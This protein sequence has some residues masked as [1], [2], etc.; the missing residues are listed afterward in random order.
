MKQFKAWRYKCD[1]CG[2]NGRQKSS[3]VRH[4]IGCTANPDRICKIHHH[5]TGEDL[6]SSPPVAEMLTLLREHSKDEDHGLKALR[7]FVD[8]CPCCI[9][10]AI[11]QSG[12]CK[13]YAD[14]DGYSPPA[15]GPEQ[16][17]FKKELASLW[18]EVNGAAHEASMRSEAHYL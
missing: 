17:D 4:E 16:F 14:E 5:A 18:A 15:I 11:R 2:K 3:M 9:L 7:D 8:N 10:A 1:F 12:L 13:G 6:P